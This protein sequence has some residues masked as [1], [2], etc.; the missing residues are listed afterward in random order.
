M[1]SWRP[2]DENYSDFVKVEEP[3]WF[4]VRLSNGSVVSKNAISCSFEAVRWL[5]SDR[6]TDPNRPSVWHWPE[7]QLTSRWKK[8]LNDRPTELHQR[9]REAKLNLTLSNRF[10]GVRK[11]E[12]K[13][14]VIVTFK[15]DR[16]NSHTKSEASC[17]QI[18]IAR[19]CNE[20]FLAIFK[21]AKG[22]LY[23]SFFR[24]VL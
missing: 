3:T 15:P 11:V 17:N 6:P 2:Q 18:R 10:A 24:C 7:I 14:N 19:T 4:S 13:V 21:E 1:G 23:A 9:A 16:R 5:F 22:C 12:H 20:F 8:E